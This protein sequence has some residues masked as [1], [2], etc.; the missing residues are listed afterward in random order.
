MPRGPEAEFQSWIVSEALTRGIRVSHDPDS[1]RQNPGEPDLFLLSP[2][3]CAWVEVKAP[4]GILRPAQ[5]EWHNWLVLAGQR[6]L[7]VAPG[8]EA[9]V[10]ALLDSLAPQNDLGAP[11]PARTGHCACAQRQTPP[12]AAQRRDQAVSR[13]DL[14]AAIGPQAADRV[15]A[16][17]GV[18]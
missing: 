12:G 1:R 14:A 7:I 2:R 18:H 8:D 9:Q 15:L 13:D 11:A 17:R 4:S 6:C 5:R 10:L 3:G 16:T